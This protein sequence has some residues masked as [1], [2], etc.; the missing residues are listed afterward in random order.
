MIRVLVIKISHEYL[1]V[2]SSISKALIL[3][4]QS[5]VDLCHFSTKSFSAKFSIE[6]EVF[7]KLIKN[8]ISPKERL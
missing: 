2:F 6:N 1:I 3:Y 7:K 8:I 5:I 4:G